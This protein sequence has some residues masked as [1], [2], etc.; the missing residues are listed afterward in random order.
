MRLSFA[1]LF[2]LTL[3]SLASTVHAQSLNSPESVEYDAANQRELISNRGAGQI[4]ARDGAGNLSVFVS[5]ASSVAG[6]EIVGAVLYANIG[7]TLRGYRLSDAVEVVTVPIA[8]ATFLNGITSNGTD[9]LWLSDFSV[10]RLHEVTIGAAGA[11]VTTLVATT[12]NTPNGLSYD[13][14]NNRL[15]VASWGGSASIYEYRFATQTYQVLLNTTFSNMDGL[16]VDC[17][18]R[19]YV[20]HWGN[21]ASSIQRF[22]QPLTS[23][24]TASLFV[25]SGLSNPA[26]ITF[27]AANGRI[28]V[29]NAGNST[30][31]ASAVSECA[32]GNFANGF[33]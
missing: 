4:L 27:D 26:D 6:L 7:G 30:V 3:L 21:P 23:T 18:N 32:P 11:T 29:P 16:A 33:E 31:S 22:A 8:G 17:L 13:R 2:C 19:L 10:R 28:L 9:K 14:A 20:S 15:L 12:P 24:S 1:K 25:G 5:S